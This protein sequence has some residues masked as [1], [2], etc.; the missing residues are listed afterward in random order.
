MKAKGYPDYII[1]SRFAK[2]IHT[3]QTDLLKK[4]IK[5]EV[6]QVNLTLTF[7]YITHKLQGSINKHWHITGNMQNIGD[8]LIKSEFREG[9]PSKYDI[10]TRA[11]PAQGHRPCGHCVC[12]QYACKMTDFLD[13]KSGKRS[14]LKE[15]TDS[16]TS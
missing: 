6:N 11:T 3:I 14:T 9:K 16:N 15:F 10:L 1:K 5:K 2:V 7:D 8:V 13:H 4:R 12:C